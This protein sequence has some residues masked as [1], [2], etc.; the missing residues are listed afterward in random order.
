[1]DIL[2]DMDNDLK[3]EGI[4]GQERIKSTLSLYYRT[5]LNTNKFPFLLFIGP[6][7]IGKT[8]FV[9]YVAK[10]IT[11]NNKDNYLEINCGN[12]K[13]REDFFFN[14]FRDRIQG[15]SKF[16]FFDECHNLPDEI[17]Q[18]FLTIFNTE[19]DTDILHLDFQGEILEF[20]FT[21]Q[22]YVFATTEP[23][24]LFPPL[25][26][27]LYEI[28][29]KDY[30]QDELAQIILE[31]TDCDYTPDSLKFVASLVR[32]NARDAIKKARMVQMF[33]DSIGTGIKRFEMEHSEDFLNRTGILP[34]G[35]HRD[36][37]IILK[38]L[39]ECGPLSLTNIQAKTGLS[40]GAIQG[41][42]EQY[43]QRRNFI[44][45]DEGNSKRKKT[46]EGRAIIIEAEKYL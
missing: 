12:L 22:Q 45:I 2:S 34:G 9:R 15:T 26:D 18:I 5:Y 8:K 17:A 39:D 32:G 14:I 28:G 30:D 24:R 41:V 23:Q 4:V 11:K 35:L 27:R 25:L 19:K 40:R 29:F 46:K 13:K 37:A 31:S 33:C 42:Y 3:F 20:D 21:K 16:T 10:Q 36:E 1:M 43:L 6:K 38:H 44:T 7:G